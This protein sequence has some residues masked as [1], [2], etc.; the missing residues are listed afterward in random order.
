MVIHAAVI[1]LHKV[2]HTENRVILSDPAGSRGGVEESTHWVDICTQI[3]A[4]NVGEIVVALAFSNCKKVIFTGSCGAL[5]PNIE[6]GDIFL[7]E[8]SFLNIKYG[9]CSL[10]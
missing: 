6:I 10:V 5:K 1:L 2:A 3:G 8:F 4:C 7:P 9:T